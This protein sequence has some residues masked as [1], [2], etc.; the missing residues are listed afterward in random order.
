MFACRDPPEAPQASSE[1]HGTLIVLATNRCFMRAM[2]TIDIA[3][4]LGPLEWETL[5]SL[6]APQPD[7]GRVHAAALRQ[8][9][10]SELVTIEAER[11]SV[12]A[13][14]RQVVICGSPRLWRG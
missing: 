14:G 13:R 11:P 8:L 3:D 5:K 1:C 9:L 10:Q 12:T 2:Q 7:R 4:S 6:S